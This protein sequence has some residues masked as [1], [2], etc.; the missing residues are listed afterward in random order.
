MKTIEWYEVFGFVDNV[1]ENGTETKETFDTLEE[2]ENY[3]NEHNTEDL[4]ID[5]WEMN[6]DGSG[7]AKRN[8]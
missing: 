5:A 8:F 6:E 3:V 4:Y 1:E 7:V 2:A